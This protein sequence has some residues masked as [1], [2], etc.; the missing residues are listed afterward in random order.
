[1]FCA[2]YILRALTSKLTNGTLPV[3]ELHRGDPV[4]VISRRDRLRAR[5]F[6]TLTIQSSHLFI[7]MRYAAVNQLTFPTVV[8]CSLQPAYKNC[9]VR[10][11]K[12]YPE[13]SPNIFL[14]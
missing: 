6:V 4:A 13:K 8:P 10:L 5:A 2:N 3:S 1:M 11:E 12:W 7:P 9:A 14:V